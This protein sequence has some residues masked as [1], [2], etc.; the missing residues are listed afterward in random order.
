MGSG[1]ALVLAGDSGFSA[2][3]W[4][5]ATASLRVTVP[6]QEPFYAHTRCR[7]HRDKELIA[8]TVLPV[9]VD[10]DDTSR[11]EVHWDQVPTTEQRIQDGDR[12]ILDPEGTW[13]MVA[14]ARSGMPSS[15]SS[16]VSGPEPTQSPWRGGQ[17]EG[18]PR[19]EPLGDGRRPGT[20]LV[21]SR[22]GDPAGYRSLNDWRLPCQPCGGTVYDGS[23]DYLGWLLLCVV[24]ES[25]PRYGVHVRKRLRRDHL[26]AVLPVAIHPSKARDIEIPWRY[27][28]NTTRE[29]TERLRTANRSAL[30]TVDQR[31]AGRSG[32][33]EAALAEIAD[34][35]AHARTE[36]M[37]KKF[38]LV[39][40]GGAT[41][42]G[43]P[44]A[45]FAPGP[46]RAESNEES[47]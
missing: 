34:P 43:G 17:I 3:S 28:P 9:D 35:V 21:V 39:S 6:G 31:F 7:V 29:M 16:G 46:S 2:L 15:V 36:E 42:A 23:H 4:W 12:A 45:P 37:L 38:G 11:L 19:A 27:S 44:E 40:G 24:P 20:A 10:P 33:G 13:R 22:A 25:G 1:E 18:W 14:E 47:D 41:P 26:G 8:G 30:E 5:T 32:L